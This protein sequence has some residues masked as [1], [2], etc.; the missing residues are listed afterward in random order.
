MKVGIPRGLLFN[1]FSPLFIPFFNYLGI[2]TVVSDNTNRKIINRGLELVPAEYCFPTKVAYGHIDNLLEKDVDFVFIPYIANTG[3]PTGNYKY[4]VTC[5]WTQSTPDLMK[6]APK[7]IEKG[8]NLEKLV[9]PS[10]IFDWG[11]N[12]IEDQMKKSVVKMGYSTR[13]VRAALHEGF[14]N[15][16]IFDKRINEKTKEVFYSIKEYKK[17]EPAFLVMARPY[18][19]YDANVN[20]DIANKIL[21][22]GYLAIP[23]ELAPIGS[24]DLSEQMPKMYWVQGQKKLE[25]EGK[26]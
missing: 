18:T 23:L 26:A 25:G 16:K 11:L 7:L 20:N 4:S 24:I 8:F 6:S 14:I 15:K 17:N 13:N 2:K 12:H 5:P 21:D 22:A 19:A 9:S 1:D 10:L 3:E